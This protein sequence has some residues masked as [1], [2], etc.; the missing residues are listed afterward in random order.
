MSADD[1]SRF[2]TY[3]RSRNGA[4]PDHTELPAFLEKQGQAP[5]GILGE[6]DN[7]ITMGTVMRIHNAATGDTVSLASANVALQLSKHTMSLYVY[8]PYDEASDGDKLAKLAERWIKC[9]RQ[10][11]E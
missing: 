10:H 5:L 9:L 8:R 11:N 6:T 1:F 3:A 4:I 2:A 7:S